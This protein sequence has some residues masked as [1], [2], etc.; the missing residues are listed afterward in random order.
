MTESASCRNPF[1]AIGSLQL[2][3]WARE[4]RVTEEGR[5]KHA[6][7]VRSVGRERVAISTM[8]RT[9]HDID[10]TLRCL[11]TLYLCSTFD[12]L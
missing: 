6:R 11:G 8:L 4:R 3:D 9:L 1:R 7:C 5:I 12:T 2:G 10:R